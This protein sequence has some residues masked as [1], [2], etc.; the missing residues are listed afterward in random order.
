VAEK[1]DYRTARLLFVQRPDLGTDELDRLT[2]VRLPEG[3]IAAW[4]AG[5]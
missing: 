2:G 4:L 5:R 3:A 1:V